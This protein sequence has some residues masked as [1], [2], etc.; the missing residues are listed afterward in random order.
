MAEAHHG[1]GSPLSPDAGLGER[2]EVLGAVSPRRGSPAPRRFPPCA[3]RWRRA[4]RWS[5]SSITARGTDSRRQ[6]RDRGLLCG[7]TPGRRTEARPV[8]AE[9]VSWSSLS[10]LVGRQCPTG[11]W[12]RTNSTTS[13]RPLFAGTR[14]GPLSGS[15]PAA[16]RPGRRLAPSSRPRSRRPATYVDEHG[17]RSPRDAPASRATSRARLDPSRCGAE[18][19]PRTPHPSSP[20]SRVS[21]GTC[22]GRARSAPLPTASRSSTA[23]IGDEGA[24]GAQAMQEPHPAARRRNVHVLGVGTWST[25]PFRSCTVARRLPRVSVRS[26]AGTYADPGGP[27]HAAPRGA[28]GQDRAQQD[29][30]HPK[31]GRCDGRSVRPGAAR[32]RTSRCESACSERRLLIATAACGGGSAVRCGP[33]RCRTHGGRGRV[34]SPA[35]TSF[36]APATAGPASGP[37]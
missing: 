10:Q 15:A 21:F 5:R 16:P 37:R 33:I 28:T 14:P 34:P 4:S 26:V 20:Q 23:A 35:A 24:T 7:P 32:S 8:R 25:P 17:S 1:T 9:P 29:T 27:D 36:E 2:D 31:A 3:S 18:G 19:T 11:T 12:S 6:I 13:L 22:R 30:W